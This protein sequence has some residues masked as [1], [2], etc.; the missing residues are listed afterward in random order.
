MKRVVWLTDIHLNFLHASQ[1]RAFVGQ[2]RESQPDVVLLGGDIAES[3]NVESYLRQIWATVQ[4]PVYFVLGNHDYYYSSIGRVRE[5]VEEL[6]RQ[7]PGLT[8]LARAG[9]VE[10]AAGVGLVGHDGWG[11]ARLGDF[12]ASPVVLN[13]YVLIE[14]LAQIGKERRR[15]ALESL[16]D[17]AAAHFRRVLPAALAEYPEVYLLTHVPPFRE[18]CW[19]EGAISNDQWLPHF[20][21]KAVGDELA[22]IMTAHPDRQLT[23]LCGHTHSPGEA[24][25]LPNLRVLTGGAQYGRPVIQQVFELG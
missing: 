23:V 8:W 24:R 17:E 13:D 20:T 3:Q 1:S 21:C 15:V 9:V 2:V 25:P 16:G 12:F 4:C 6:C 22:A 18:A 7:T 5:G 11:D 19:H 14:D 10:L